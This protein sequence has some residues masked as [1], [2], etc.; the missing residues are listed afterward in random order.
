MDDLFF[1]LSNVCAGDRQRDEDQSETQDE[2]VDRVRERWESLGASWE[3]EEPC[4]NCGQ[5]HPIVAHLTAENGE[6]LLRKGL[7][8][9]EVPSPAIQMAAALNAG[10]PLRWSQMQALVGH[11]WAH[12]AAH[13]VEAQRRA[14]SAGNDR[15]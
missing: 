13:G 9:L 14:A 6:W 12:G 5:E 7:I 10:L 1:H 8:L 15:P 4:P 2:F 3:D 11:A